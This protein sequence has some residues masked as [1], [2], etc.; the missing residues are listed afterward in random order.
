MGAALSDGSGSGRGIALTGLEGKVIRVRGFRVS[1]L[2]R[3]GA[4]AI[5]V[6]RRT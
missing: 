4:L 3:G 1:M 6:M 5:G 2:H